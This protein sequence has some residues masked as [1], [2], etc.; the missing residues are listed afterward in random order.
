MKDKSMEQHNNEAVKIFWTGG[1]DSTFRVLQVILF[2]KRKVQ[3]F[4]IID[5]GR[6]STDA[7]IKA[8]DNIKDQLSQRY[9]STKELLLPTVIGN[10]SDIEGSQEVTDAYQGI[11]EQQ[12]LGSQYEF[13]ANY[14][15]QEGLD[16]LEIAAEDGPAVILAK[17]LQSFVVQVNAGNYPNYELDVKYDG[18]DVYTLFKYFR[19]PILFTTKLEM[20]EIVTKEKLEDLMDL[21]WFCHNPQ[22]R[23]ANYEPCGVCNPCIEVI[24]AGMGRRMPLR[25]KIRY[26]FRVRSRV[27]KLSRRYPKFFDFIRKWKRKLLIK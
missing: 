26:Y 19:Y 15:L 16:H 2:E 5:P 11:L 27:K 1:W 14:C 10:L 20:Q 12:E 24:S 6:K 23:S 22:M 25:S 4:Y 17:L 21:T 18:T 9:P 13:L 3:P 7:E 8:M